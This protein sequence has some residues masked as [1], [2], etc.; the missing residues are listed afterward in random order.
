MNLARVAPLLTLLAIA[1]AAQAEPAPAQPSGAA[2]LA[3]PAPAEFVIRGELEQGGWIR[4]RLP[5]GTVAAALGSTPLAFD[6]N[7]NFF[8]AFDRDQDGALR[9]SVTRQDGQVAARD[10]SVKPRDWNIERVNAPLRPGRSSEAFMERRRPELEAIWA[11]R[12]KDTQ[13]EGWR[14]D[15]IWPAKGR[16]S[17]RF[18]SQRI[19]QGQPGSYHSGLDIA[20]GDGTTYVAPAAGTVVLAVRGFS[21]EGNLLIIDHGQGLNSAFLHSSELFV[22][23][24]DRVEQGQPL[25][26]IGASGR[27]AGPHLHWSL[28][29]RDARLDPLLFLPSM[30]GE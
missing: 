5:A 19:Y 8:A 15:F 21:L 18:G 30:S 16:I 2:P 10:L 9:L 7:G 13:S 27:A 20:G 17:G 28:K 22:K 4:G 14:Q 24:G 11:A 12:E 25:G 6:E 23:Q 3:Q 1:P 29:W 26:R